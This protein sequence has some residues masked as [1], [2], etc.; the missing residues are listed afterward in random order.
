MDALKAE[1]LVNVQKRILYEH[2]PLSAVYEF[3]IGNDLCLMGHRFYSEGR[4]HLMNAILMDPSF[5]LAYTSLAFT[6]M[7][8]R[9]I[10]Q[11]SLK[12]ATEKYG[13]NLDAAR[14]LIDIA[15]VL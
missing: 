7:D 10:K 15:S 4:R 14:K 1:N 12:N 2:A 6:Y 5:I 8:Q 11:Y 13:Y 3:R 9:L